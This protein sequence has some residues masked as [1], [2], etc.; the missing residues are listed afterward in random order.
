MIKTNKKNKII[1]GN[2]DGYAP[3]PFKRKGVSSQSERGYAILE[4]L[5]YISFFVVLSLL[6]INSMITMA[7]S[8]KETS[9]RAELM[10]GGDVVERISREIRRANSIN[11]VGSGSLILNTKDGGGAVVTMQFLLS[12]GNIQLLES[13]ALTGNLNTSNTNITDLTFTQINTIKGGA[14]RIVLT[15]ESNTNTGQYETFYNTVVLRGDY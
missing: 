13:G 11:S 10:K 5:F 7:R 2:K 1:L 9:I 8:F 4:L 12:S 6:V 15:L 3:T 14:V